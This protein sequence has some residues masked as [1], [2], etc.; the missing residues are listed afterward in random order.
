[1]SSP[2]FANIGEIMTGKLETIRVINTVKEAASKMAA[3][4]VSSLAVVH[5]D[6]RAAGIVTE[7]DL[8]RR[9]CTTD[10]L[11][12]QIRVQEILSAPVK[13]VGLA[14]P[15]G[16]AA[17]FMVKNKIRHLLVIDEADKKPLGIVSATDVLAY[18]RENSAAMMQVDKDVI[19]ALE[20]EGRFYF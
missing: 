14:T 11:S 5:E 2:P 6:G 20:K 19:R 10:R 7:R 4:N 16:E 17:D 18:V 8:V 3:K 9:V 15:I 13:T 12:S 1:M